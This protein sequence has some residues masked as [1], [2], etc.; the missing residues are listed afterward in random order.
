[1]SQFFSAAWMMDGVIDGIIN[2]YIESAY[3]WLFALMDG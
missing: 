2:R 3:F 1:M